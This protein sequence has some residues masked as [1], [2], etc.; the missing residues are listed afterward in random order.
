MLHDK[1]VQAGTHHIARDGRDDA[2]RP[3]S[4]GVYTCELHAD[5]C[6][7]VRSVVPVR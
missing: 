4:T 2:N 3:L 7:D 5:G 6:R 1:P